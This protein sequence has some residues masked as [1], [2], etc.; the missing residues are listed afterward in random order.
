MRLRLGG[1][2]ARWIGLLCSTAF[3]AAS[4]YCVLETLAAHPAPAEGSHHSD[5]AGHDSGIPARGDDGE[6]CCIALQSVL[7]PATDLHLARPNVPVHSLSASEA[8]CPKLPITSPGST[9]GWSPPE[10]GSPPATPFYRTT[11]ASHAPPAFL[12]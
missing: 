5:T 3:F 4:N 10:R 11:F 9:I 12:A 7:L 8:P 2:R 6:L 1:R